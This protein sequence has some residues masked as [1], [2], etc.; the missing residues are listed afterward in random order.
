MPR[1]LAILLALVLAGCSA[2]RSLQPLEK[3]TGAITA[4]FGGPIN[5]DLGAAIPLPFSSVGYMHGLDGKTNVYGAFYPSGL[6]IFGVPGIDLG[7][8]REVL[9]PQGARPRIMVDGVFY[10]FAGNAGEGV[11][12]A[13][14]RVWFDAA[15]T[16]VWPIRDKHALFTS[17][18]LFMQP[19]PDAFRAYVNPHVGGQ[20]RIGRVGLQLEYTWWGPWVNTRFMQPEWKGPGGYGASTVQL[21]FDVRLGKQGGT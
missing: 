21:G 9:T 3:G 5:A 8:S 1:L 18:D 16:F 2:T 7:V 10:G 13:G 12:P 14:G 4:S 20:L 19:G 17:L 6:L 11:P 15:S